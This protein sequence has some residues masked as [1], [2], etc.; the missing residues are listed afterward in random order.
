I[1]EIVPINPLADQ[2]ENLLWCTRTILVIDHSIKQFDY[3]P[4]APEAFQHVPFLLKHGLQKRGFCFAHFQLRN[5]LETH[6]LAVKT[7]CVTCLTCNIPFMTLPK[8]LCMTS[9]I[10]LNRRR[11][12]ECDILGTTSF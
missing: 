5:L 7:A 1:G 10:S 11:N 8:E 3:G 9:S 2:S 12:D 6:Q 4:M